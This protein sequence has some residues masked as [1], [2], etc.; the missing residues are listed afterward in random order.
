MTIQIEISQLLDKIQGIGAGIL[1]LHDIINQNKKTH[2]EEVR[3][4]FQVMEVYGQ[5][6]EI[7][8][9]PEVGD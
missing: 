4:F 5:N 2:V 1:T 9:K 8:G 3:T 6:T 7:T